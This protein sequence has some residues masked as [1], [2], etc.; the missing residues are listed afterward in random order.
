MTKLNY[1]ALP[2]PFYIKV[3]NAMFQARWHAMPAPGGL[4]HCTKNRIAA[5]FCPEIRILDFRG[6]N[7]EFCPAPSVARTRKQGI[8]VREADHNSTS[9]VPERAHDGQNTPAI[10]PA[11]TRARGQVRTTPPLGF[12]HL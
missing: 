6:Q 2:L 1:Y 3:A 8:F 12:A 10:V 5:D 7:S 11:D 4:P 9:F